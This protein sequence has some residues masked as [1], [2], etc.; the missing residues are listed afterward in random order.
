[1][2]ILVADRVGFVRAS[3]VLSWFLANRKPIASLEKS[4][5]GTL[6]DLLGFRRIQSILSV[7]GMKGRLLDGEVSV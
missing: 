4:Y 6:G 7:K 3:L 5:L 2:C 1:M